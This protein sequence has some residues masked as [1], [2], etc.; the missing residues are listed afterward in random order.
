MFC[1]GAADAVWLACLVSG[2]GAFLMGTDLVFGAMGTQ[3]SFGFV[4]VDVTGVLDVI[5]V[6]RARPVCIGD[7]D[8][9]AVSRID[10]RREGL[11]IS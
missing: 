6:G 5:D 1:V 2:T 4:E 3:E 11:T 10:C 9:L 8:S 7:F